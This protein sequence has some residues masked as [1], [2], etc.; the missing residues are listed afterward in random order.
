MMKVLCAVGS[1]GGAELVLQ[2]IDILG[3]GCE[4]CLVHVIDEGPRHHLK[5]LHGP[6]RHGPLGGPA[7]ER[8]MSAAE[9]SGGHAAL[10]DALEAAKKAGVAAKSQLKRGNPEHEIVELAH[11]IGASLILI[12]AREGASRHPDHGPGSVGHT[13]RFVLDH[14][15][16][17]VLLLREPDLS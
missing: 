3:K 10:D 13:A 16:C 15:P 14:A 7:R 17:A 4:L 8:E 1:R 5:H 12:R 9:E 2:T 11:E 6:L